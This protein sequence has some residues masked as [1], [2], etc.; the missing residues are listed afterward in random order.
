MNLLALINAVNAAG[1]IKPVRL[2]DITSSARQYAKLL[3]YAEPTHCPA[4]AYAKPK[5][6]RDDLIAERLPE[7]SAIKL[8]NVKNNLS[9]L[10]RH[11]VELGLLRLD[12]VTQLPQA[13]IFS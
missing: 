13:H 10:F 1:R 11:A 5:P 4:A 7:A 2:K 9:F 8:R 6:V 12:T 3:G